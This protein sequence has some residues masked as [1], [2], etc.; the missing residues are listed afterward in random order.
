M[1]GAQLSEGSGVKPE[2]RIR[3]KSQHGG[4]RVR[5]KRRC[6]VRTLPHDV[7]EPNQAFKLPALNFIELCNSPVS[8]GTGRRLE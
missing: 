8:F 5:L 1:A 2:R 4:D 6:A 7:V 3:H